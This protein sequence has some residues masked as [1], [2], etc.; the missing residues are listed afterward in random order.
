MRPRFASI[1]LLLPVAACAWPQSTAIPDTPAGHTFRPGPTPSIATAG[2]LFGIFLVGAFA[3]V[4][5]G[6]IH[7][8][9]RLALGLAVGGPSE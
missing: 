5:Y 8:S 3:A 6:T 9:G 7:M 4:N 2:F 1:L